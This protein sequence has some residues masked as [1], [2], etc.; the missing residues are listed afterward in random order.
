MERKMKPHRIVLTSLICAAGASLSIAAGS[1]S[2]STEERL[3]P[4]EVADSVRA[5]MDPKADACQDFYQ[6]ACGGWLATAQ[7]PADQP[8]WSRGFADIHERNIAALRQ[9]LDEAAAAPQGDPGFV[10]LGGFYGACMDEAAAER[11]GA[12]PLKPL[13]DE[14]AT[15][16]DAAGLM[17][18]AGKLHR[19]GVPVLFDLMEDS[20]FKDPNIEIVH[21]F[22]GGLGM[23]DRDYY[24]KEEEAT[25]GL[26]QEY[27][28][29]AGRMLALL[30]EKPDDAARHAKQ[31]LA[32]EKGLAEVSWPREETRQ[33]EK[34]YHKLDI[35]GLKELAPQL[36]WDAFLVA[37][38][39]PAIR[40]INVAI[41]DFVKGMA[42]LAART[43]PETLRT[44]LRVHLADGTANLLS[45]AFV[46]ERFAIESKFTGQK[47]IQP[48]W[49][50][51]VDAADQAMGELLGRYFV[52]RRFAGDSKTIA[53]KMIGGIESAFESSLPTLSWMDPVTRGRASEKMHAISNKIGYPDRWRDYSGLTVTRGDWFASATAARA[54]EFARQ[55]DKVGKKKDRTEWGM[56]PPTVNAYY[57]PLVNE[58][59]FPA[60]IL[61][62]PF[63]H[64]DLPASM[65]FG[66]MG[67]V[68]GH[69]LTHGFDDQGRK[70][71]AQG[72]LAE[73]WEPSVVAKF[74]ERT[75]CVDDLYDTYEVQPGVHL[76][77][78][79]TLG[80]NIADMGGL[81]EA[82]RAYRQWPRDAGASP[83]VEGITDD[84]LFFVG[85]AQTWCSKAQP[86]YERMM[87]TV[88]EHSA[89]RFRVIGPVSNTIEFAEAFKCPA[90]SPMRPA[91][92]C[93][94][95]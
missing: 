83:A 41:P 86:E 92:T 65:N 50:R 91:K 70:F 80:E 90:G 64:R 35:G 11:A 93:E 20:D 4:K 14:I 42:A 26:R 71:D 13:L 55:I 38:G 46:D 78:K 52:E 34:L 94:V 21:L 18:V 48:R 36:P 85:F 76:N 29:H 79:L 25:R 60:G 9:I 28:A 82:Y 84:Q 24:L 1:A 89:P 81:K 15:V 37:A 56:T 67:M 12:Q 39:G 58:I 72:R 69:E 3:T 23:P 73:W 7:I 54:F 51:C 2:G 49:K 53:L 66:G 16:K 57:N 6:Y 95:W 22:Q 44:Y 31:L 10:K 75:Q 27:E 63:F 61:Q 30:G 40:D 19:I 8:T 43:D 74:D 62:R 17:A 88:N 33:M 45:K 32:F 68:V 77:G 5:T 87:A 59:V 47:E